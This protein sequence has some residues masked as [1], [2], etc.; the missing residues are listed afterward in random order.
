MKAVAYY[1]SLIDGL[2][3]NNIQPMVTL[4]HWDLPQILQ[5]YTNF[6]KFQHVLLMFVTHWLPTCTFKFFKMQ[7]IF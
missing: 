3:R 5:V 6:L 2:L 1:N 4:Y 7:T